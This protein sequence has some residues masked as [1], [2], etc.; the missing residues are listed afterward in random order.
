MKKLLNKLFLATI[1]VAPAFV[2]AASPFLKPVKDV[3]GDL[4]IFIKFLNWALPALGVLLFFL[5][6]LGFIG[7]KFGF[8]MF[9]FFG[10]DAKKSTNLIW[11]IVGLACMFAVYGLI[12]LM[13]ALFGVDTNRAKTIT[14]PSLPQ[15]GNIQQGGFYV[16]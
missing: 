5:L 14:A 16:Q 13:G 11:G 2:F 15:V 3:L 9:G 12:Q 7:S 4:E 8:T 1:L 6:I 10:D